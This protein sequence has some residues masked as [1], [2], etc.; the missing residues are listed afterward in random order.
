MGIKDKSLHAEA[1]IDDYSM[2]LR[3]GFGDDKKKGFLIEGEVFGKKFLIDAL[4]QNDGK[5]YAEGKLLIETPI[6]GFHKMGGLFTYSNMNQKVVAKSEV[7][8]PTILMNNP[9]LSGE[10]SLDLNKKA[11]GFISMNIAGEVFTLKSNIIETSQKGYKG[12]LELYTPFHALSEVDISGE[13]QMESY[14]NIKSNFNLKTPFGSYNIAV[15]GK[16]EKQNNKLDYEII[17]NQNRFTIN[18][19]LEDYLKQISIGATVNG[20]Q[21]TIS[22][23][24]MIHENEARQIDVTVTSNSEEHK[25]TGLFN[26]DTDFVQG[27]LEINSRIIGGKRK[28]NFNLTIP[29]TPFRKFSIDMGLSASETHVFQL[30]ID[31]TNNFKLNINVE[32]SVIPDCALQLLLSS[33][34]SSLMIVAP[35]GTHKLDATWFATQRIPS[36]IKGT[37]EL[38]S[39]LLQQDYLIQTSLINGKSMKDIKLHL[40]TGTEKHVFETKIVSKK[41]GGEGLIHVETPFISVKKADI[42][43]SLNFKNKFEINLAASLGDMK[44][45]F[46]MKYNFNQN[47]VVTSVISP[48]IPTGL[49][50]AEAT[51]YG[52]F[53]D[54][55]DLTMSLKN[56]EEQISGTLD[57][58]KAER[59][60]LKINTPFKGYKKMTI[61][62]TYKEKDNTV[63]K[64]FADKPIKFN[65]DLTL[66]NKNDAYV[67]YMKAE[68]SIESLKTVEAE[69][70]LPLKKFNPTMKLL[71]PNNNYGLQV[72][73]EKKQYSYKISG[74]I[75]V[76]AHNYG[77][78]MKLRNKAP[79]ELATGLHL[80]K[81]EKNFHLKTDSSF[82]SFL[83]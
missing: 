59:I 33:G 38:P 4:F 36:D 75:I 16:L 66:G 51:Q 52:N 76:D 56:S 20:V 12:S 29:Q 10:I 17:V 13:I 65:V 15:N 44:H 19:L 2:K 39:P 27:N 48:L 77:A 61:G 47:S 80:P 11:D 83:N 64:I 63:V 53:E 73:F 49:A 57:L 41:N 50:Q 46:V 81:Y 60:I 3:G 9:K 54:G 43:F 18:V 31:T 1:G 5:E 21:R 34:S 62:A 78:H 82:L 25:I 35:N 55:L 71:L 32:S 22:F 26:I 37:L 79:Y 69:I 28:I 14:N 23:D 24:T 8:M 40:I 45:S 70:N 6:Y 67:A 42:E 30:D 68:T 72:D 7:I 58:K 74:D